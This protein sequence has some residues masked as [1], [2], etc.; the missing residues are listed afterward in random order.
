MITRKFK[1]VALI[2]ALILGLSAVNVGFAIADTY[3][4]VYPKTYTLSTTIYTYSGKANTPKVTIKDT[5]GKIIDAKKY[6]L[7]YKN[8]VKPGKA[9]VTVTYL[10]EAAKAKTLNYIIIPKKASKPTL[11]T[12]KQKQITVTLKEN[13]LV[14][15][16]QIR[17]STSKTF[18]NAKT[19]HL[20]NY[21]G[22]T[23]TLTKLKNNKKYYVSIRAYKTID[24]K[25]YYGEWSS[26]V[27]KKTSSKL[28]HADLPDEMLDSYVVDA[29]RYVGYKID[30]QAKA[31]SLL[32][33]YA[34]G[35]RTPTRYRSG[36]SY[37]GGPDGQ[38]TV[39]NKK[40]VSGKAPNVKKFKRE[41]L[42]CASFVSYY[43]LNYLPN[44]AGVDTS[45][46][47]SAIKKSGIASRQCDAW[48]YAAEYL[49][50]KGKATVV[51]S[52][53]RGQSLPAADVD[54]LQIGDLITFRIP[55]EGLEWGH[56]AV[57]AG[58]NN[59]GDHFVAHVGSDEGPVFQTL[60][61]FENIV[62]EH[63]GCA[64][65]KVY[66]FKG[67]SQSKYD[68]SVTLNKKSFKY[69]GKA[70]KPTV[71]VKDATG[72]KISSKNYTLYYR[73]NTKKGTASVHV[74]FKGKYK[75]TKKVNFKI[76]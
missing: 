13:T 25:K 31:G 75:G 44:I 40:T 30:K 63:D 45:F 64:Y 71:T 33:D 59:E 53:K 36:I 52:V 62:H 19:C 15:G 24:G 27:S 37:G 2:M 5:E 74:V 60:E 76:K 51:D 11:S 50:K 47:K 38:E 72:K 23:K 22:L 9:S 69:T 3:E 32:Q 73:N 49:V 55:N 68:Y 14:T 7:S 29:M 10:G 18:K 35:P 41:G 48:G 1:L 39:K 42:V 16:H 70:I 34:S 57:Y 6:S 21:K 58:T 8:N 4:K 12:K 54:K 56:V 66:R 67:V 28:P 43:Y 20:S 46:I 17:Y 61:R 65:K 26:K